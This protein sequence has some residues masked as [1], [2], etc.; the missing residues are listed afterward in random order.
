MVVLPATEMNI[1]SFEGS[2]DQRWLAL[3]RMKRLRDEGERGPVRGEWRE[4]GKEEILFSPF[5]FFPFICT[6]KK[7]KEKENDHIVPNLKLVFE[8]SNRLGLD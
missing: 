4:R 3:E 5:L 7:E 2:I 1:K 6:N 8:F